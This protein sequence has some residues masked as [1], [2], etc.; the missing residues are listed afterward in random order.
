MYRWFVVKGDTT[1]VQLRQIVQL[2]IS[3][4]NWYLH[5]F[6]IFGRQYGIDDTGGNQIFRIPRLLGWTILGYILKAPFAISMI[7]MIAGFI[8]YG[9]KPLPYMIVDIGIHVV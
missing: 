9:S 2:I 6:Q 8:N 5:Y 7:I 1:M 4:D 3:W